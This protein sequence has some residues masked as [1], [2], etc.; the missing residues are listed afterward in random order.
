MK[1]HDCRNELNDFNLR[2]TPARVATMKCLET[3]DKPVDVNSIIDYLKTENV[4]VDPATI[5]RMMNLFMERGLIKQ[6]RF[7]DAITRYEL[8]NKGDHHHLIC[9]SC[10]KIEAISDTV[11]P[12]MEKYIK[13]KSKFK[14]KSHSLEVF[15]ICEDCQKHTS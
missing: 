7:Q 12:I 13:E 14:V 1:T 6:I 3:I 10:G 15:G 11:F 8:S 4:D 2:A 5:F 9:E